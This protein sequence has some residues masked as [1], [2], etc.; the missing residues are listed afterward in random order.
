MLN[1]LRFALRTLARAPVFTA[2]AVLSLALGIGA[3][4]AIFSLLYQVLM[5]SLPI[6]EPESIAVLHFEGA[7]N[8]TTWSDSDA[9][10]F[11]YPMYRDLRDRNQVFD[12]LIARSGAAANV[13]FN[14]QAERADAEIVSGNF[15]PVLGVHP[16]LGRLFTPADDVTPG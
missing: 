12:A 9:S 10:T 14:G 3:N 15:F 1:D 13:I 5:R 7:R 2:V 4:S 8:G 6:A 16:Q 11:S